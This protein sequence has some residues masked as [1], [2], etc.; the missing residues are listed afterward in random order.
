MIFR[1]SLVSALACCLVTAATPACD[2]SEKEEKA[3]SKP[4]PSAEVVN[5]VPH[6]TLASALPKMVADWSRS[7][8]QSSATSS[9]KYQMA[10]ASV[11]FKKEV[12]GKTGT[13]DIE[14]IDGTHVPSVKSQ[15]ALMTH[16]AN[17]VHQMDLTLAG[18]HGMQQWQPI[19]GE[20]AAL[21]VIAGRFVVKAKGSLVSPTVFARAM[22]GIDVNEL[23][24]LAG[25]TPTVQTSSSAA[26]VPT[27]AGTSIGAASGPQGS[28]STGAPTRGPAHQ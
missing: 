17:D 5:A 6:E 3:V 27:A 26:S 14:L 2:R 22:E 18:Y 11:T 10:R 28:T 7:E 12:D 20:V 21:V 9:G 16:S 23:E 25:V 24:V 15:L 13:L 4:F 8:P 1:N 19:E